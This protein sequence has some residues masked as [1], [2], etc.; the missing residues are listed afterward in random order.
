M[1]FGGVDHLPFFLARQHIP[2]LDIF[3]DPCAAILVFIVTAL[4][5]VGIREVISP[6]SCKLDYS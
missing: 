1:I 5:C 4:L 6:C 3:V 2:L